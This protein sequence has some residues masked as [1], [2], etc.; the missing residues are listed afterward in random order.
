M[1]SLPLICMFTAERRA[2][3]VGDGMHYVIF[4]GDIRHRRLCTHDVTFTSRAG[5]GGTGCSRHSSRCGPKRLTQN[6]I[7][8]RASKTGRRTECRLSSLVFFAVPPKLGR[9][10]LSSG[11]PSSRILNSLLRL[12]HN[13]PMIRVWD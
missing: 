12:W 13:N 11:C 1:R 9:I 4:I 7:S 2:L 5:G 10:Y 6:P 8:V 3:G